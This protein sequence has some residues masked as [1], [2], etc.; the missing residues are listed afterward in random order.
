MTSNDHIVIEKD[1][2]GVVHQY[3]TNWRCGE[4]LPFRQMWPEKW[5]REAR[6]ATSK[7]KS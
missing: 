7:E 2:E 6:E 3:H 4:L 1:E 5:K